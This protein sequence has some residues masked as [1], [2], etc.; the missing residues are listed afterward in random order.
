MCYSKHMVLRN[1]KK[2]KQENYSD[3][4]YNRPFRV[5][6]LSKLHLKNTVHLLLK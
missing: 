1:L 5:V 4:I 6:G 3:S 2:I